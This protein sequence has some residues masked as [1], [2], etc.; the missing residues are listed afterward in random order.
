MYDVI[1]SVV[2]AVSGDAS[3]DVSSDV[4]SLCAV[5]SNFCLNVTAYACEE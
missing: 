5:V 2:F 3:F 4:V 1:G